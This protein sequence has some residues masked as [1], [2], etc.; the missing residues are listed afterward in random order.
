[1][2]ILMLPALLLAAGCEDVSLATPEPVT[3]VI[4]GSTTMR[5]VLEELADAFSRQY[6]EVLFD[7]RGGGSTLGEE[8][9]R[10]RTVTLGATTL[11]PATDE[12]GTPVADSLQRVPIGLDGVAI[13]VHPTNPTRNLTLL[14]LRDLYSGA[15]LDWVQVGGSAGEILLVSR[16]EGSGSRATFE[17]RVMGDESVSLTAVVMPTAADVVA[18]VAETPSAIGYVSRAYVRDLLDADSANDDALGVRVVPV[19]GVLPTI[20]TIARQAYF[21]IQPLYL[22]AADAPTGRVR[23]FLDFAVSPAGQEI[24]ARYHAPIR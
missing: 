12:A 4:S 21:L 6:P 20:E 10:A 5:P 23:Q 13:V 17:S 2:Q 11:L 8:Q 3:I 7:L 18:Y 24:V 22:V 9:A 14:N 15:V 19:E 16:E 1:M